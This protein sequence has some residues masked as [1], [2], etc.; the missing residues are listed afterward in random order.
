MAVADAGT[1][2]PWLYGPVSDLLLGCGLL[3]AALFLAQ[4]AFGASYRNAV[5][6]AVL[7]LIVLLLGQPHYGGTLVRIYESRRE[8][9]SYAIFSV[10][11]TAALVLAFLAGIRVTWIG[12][13]LVTVYL[14][15]SPWHY[16]GQNY[17]VAVMFLRRAGVDLDA[18]TKRLL[19]LSFLL[20]FVLVFGVMHQTLGVATN[21]LSLYGG[22]NIEFQPLGIPPSIMALAMPVVIGAYLVTS[23]AWVVRLLPEASMR[24]LAPALLLSVTQALWFSLPTIVQYGGW[25]TGI[26]VFRQEY[27]AYYFTF[28]AGGHSLQ[29]LWVTSYFARGSAGWQGFPVY[30]GKVL[31]AGAAVWTI[32]MWIAFVAGAGPFALDGGLTLVVAAVVNIHH[33]VLDG[34]IWKLRGPIAELLVRDVPETS[35]S[36]DR[37]A[38]PILRRAVWA[39]CAFTFVW[40]SWTLVEGERV[41]AALNRGEAHEAI[42]LQDRMAAWGRDTAQARAA[43]GQLLIAK[44]EPE[45]GRAQ[46]EKSLELSANVLTWVALGASHE[47]AGEWAEAAAVYERAIAAGNQR[48][49]LLVLAARAHLQAGDPRSA[50]DHVVRGEQLYPDDESFVRLRRLVRQRGW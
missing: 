24:A 1:R 7:P 13:L 29:Y 25:D 3:Y 30:L 16:T 33:F 37:P 43:A 35:T 18:G 40:A 2:K 10:W 36:L 31:A 12:T 8:R 34:A 17:G 23:V 49:E 4:A 27:R 5:P 48:S 42:A 22:T 11:A 9:R 41:V 32:P 39:A 15:W 45:A 44:G 38:S 14:T 26:D 47:R 20:S 6:H 19:Y 28:I 46:L 50:R 21:P